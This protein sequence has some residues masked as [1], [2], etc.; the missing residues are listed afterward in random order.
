MFRPAH[1]ALLSSSVVDCIPPDFISCL[2]IVLFHVP[3]PDLIQDLAK[4]LSPFVQLQVDVAQA[5]LLA[6]D[7]LQLD[8]NALRPLLTVCNPRSLHAPGQHL[9]QFLCERIVMLRPICLLYCVLL[10]GSEQPWTLKS[11]A[12]SFET[13]MTA[14]VTSGAWADIW[15]Y[16]NSHVNFALNL[17]LL[18]DVVEMSEVHKGLQQ[19]ELNG[20][21]PATAAIAVHA[22][23]SLFKKLR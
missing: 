18:P 23:L 4:A 10:L 15:E 6:S 8:I 3:E 17:D 7:S 19:V 16:L 21:W 13:E 5:T 1:D 11:K 9:Y 12:L 14:P 20:Q 2:Q 22:A